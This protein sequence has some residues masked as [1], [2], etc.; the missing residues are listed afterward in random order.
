[1]G[2]RI[3]ENTWDMLIRIRAICV[4][5]EVKISSDVS[6]GEDTWVR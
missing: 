2:L 1:M 6:Y 4:D 5:N 3:L